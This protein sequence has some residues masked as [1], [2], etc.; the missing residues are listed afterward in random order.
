MTFN[1]AIWWTMWGV[2]LCSKE[3]C[4]LSTTEC[5]SIIWK[6]L[7][8][9]LHMHIILI[10][11]IKTNMHIHTHMHICCIRK[12]NQH[13]CTDYSQ[14]RKTACCYHK[15]LGSLSW[16]G[17]EISGSWNIGMLTNLWHCSF[18]KS[19]SLKQHPPLDAGET[20]ERGVL[21]P[22]CPKAFVIIGYWHMR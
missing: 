3:S 10:I 13:D 9:W 2:C 15:Y 19:L 22:G 21:V 7:P 5:S 16:F 11:H 18:V 17:L 6:T 1:T 20:K 12:V 8:G 4:Y 14:C